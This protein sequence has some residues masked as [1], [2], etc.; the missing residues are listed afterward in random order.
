MKIPYYLANFFLAVSALSLSGAFWNAGF[1]LG[2]GV[3]VIISV[4]WGIFI[5]RKWSFGNGFC[6][7]LFLLGISLAAVIE[8]PRFKILVSLIAIISTWDLAVFDFLLVSSPNINHESNLIRTHLL[9]L[10]SVLTVGLSLTLLTFGM[11]LNLKFWQV[12]LL[13]I[14]LLVGLSQVFV[15]L[16]RSNND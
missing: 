9:R 7:L 6:M 10:F 16:K 5:W 12:F 3:M 13:G 14:L 11:Q 1:I 8:A 4:V 15:Q 2:A